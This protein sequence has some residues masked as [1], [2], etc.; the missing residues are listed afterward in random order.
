MLW[1]QPIVRRDDERAE[2]RSEADAAVVR[3]GPYARADTE[4]A[5]MDVYNDGEPK[6]TRHGTGFG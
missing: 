3:V 6:I 1:R 4:A 5:T 2:P